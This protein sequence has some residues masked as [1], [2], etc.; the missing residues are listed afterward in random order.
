MTDSQPRKQ[1]PP[2]ATSVKLVA[3]MPDQDL[4]PEE[5]R[6][7]AEHDGYAGSCGIP[8]AAKEDKES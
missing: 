5:I 2:S 6:E 3:A 8:A 1:V 4:T 7:M